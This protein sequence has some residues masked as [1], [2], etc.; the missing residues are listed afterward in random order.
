MKT[1]SGATDPVVLVA[2][3][4]RPGVHPN[5]LTDAL[6]EFFRYR[7]ITELV[8]DDDD[9]GWAYLVHPDAAPSDGYRDTA[10]NEFL[11]I[12]NNVPN[13]TSHTPNTH[14]TQE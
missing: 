7:E 3:R 4:L 14:G 13:F 5:S 8:N 1:N 9:N 2:V 6:N 10:R 12:A 11:N